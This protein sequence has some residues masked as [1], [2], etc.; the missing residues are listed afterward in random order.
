MELTI[1]IVS[2]LCVAVPSVIATITAN[3]KSSAI[4]DFKIE[5]LT[6]KVNIHNN[7]IDRMY[8]VETRVAVIEDEIK[9][10]K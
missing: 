9:D 2:G 3:K 4:T 10:R 7:L 6:K 1:A 5:E 8:K